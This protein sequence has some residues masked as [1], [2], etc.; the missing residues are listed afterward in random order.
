MASKQPVLLALALCMVS[1][2]ALAQEPAVAPAPVP[3]AP[4]ASAPADAAASVAA[5]AADSVVAAPPPASQPWPLNNPGGGSLGDLDRIQSEIVMAEARTKLAD[6]RL[7]LSR[8][9]GTGVDLDIVTSGPPVVAGVFGRADAPYARFLLPDGSQ[10]IGR[11][12]DQLGGG[13]RVVRIGVDKV[14]IKD[15]K[16]QEIVARFNG[17]APV[18]PGSATPGAASGVLP[19]STGIIRSPMDR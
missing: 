13:Y 4:S 1:A 17:S 3:A 2:G 12:G 7:S 6:A 5:P 10:M 8:A 19:A 18:K 14:V 16:G 9:E 15:K 11:T